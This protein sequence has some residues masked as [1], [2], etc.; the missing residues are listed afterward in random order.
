MR[1][2]LESM[3]YNPLHRAVDRLRPDE[4]E[5]LLVIVTSML[6][7]S[8]EAE[9]ADVPSAVPESAQPRLPFTAAGSWAS[10]SRR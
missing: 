9:P 6:G 7:Q 2:T 3:D 10:G 4:A 8:A 1:I 5:A